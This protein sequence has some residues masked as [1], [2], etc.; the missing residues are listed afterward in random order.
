M[1][2]C[3]GLENVEFDTNLIIY[4][5]HHKTLL[6][7]LK[8]ED[9]VNIETYCSYTNIKYEDY[10]KGELISLCKEKI[11]KRIKNIFDFTPLSDSFL[12]LS[13]LLEEEDK[14]NLLKK[15][16]GSKDEKD[17]FNMLSTALN[18]ALSEKFIFCFEDDYNNRQFIIP[19][20][21]E[22]ALLNAVKKNKEFGIYE[23]FFNYATTLSSFYGVLDAKLLMEIYNRDFPENKI[24]SE[25]AVLNL[26][27]KAELFSSCNIE[28]FF[29][30]DDTV[31]YY[32]LDPADAKDI[33]KKRISYSPYIPSRQEI[34]KYYGY[35]VY[36]VQT[37]EFSELR[38]YVNKKSGS[39][40]TTFFPIEIIKEIKLGK[41]IDFPKEI[42]LFS[43]EITSAKD[44]AQLISLYAKLVSVC[45]IWVKYGNLSNTQPD[46]TEEINQND[47][48]LPRINVDLP[49][50]CVIPTEETAQKR[51]DEYLDYIQVIEEECENAPKWVDTFLSTR[52]RIKK[53]TQ[54]VAS[55]QGIDDD[56]FLDSTVFQ[57]LVTMKS[58]LKN[59]ADSS[60]NSN[61][62]FDVFD[63]GQKLDENLF[64]CKKL[65]GSPFVLFSKAIEKLYDKNITCA[66][67]VL[68][69]LGGFFVPYRIVIP[70]SSVRAKDVE[71]LMKFSAPQIYASKGFTGV[72]QF[73][74]IPV[75]ALS[76]SL[77]KTPS[78]H[79]GKLLMKCVADTRFV[80][81][82]VFEEFLTD[83]K[84]EE[85]KKI[86]CYRLQS[87]TKDE[88]DDVFI[89]I[90]KSS[91][92]TILFAHKEDLF[93]ETKAKLLPYFDS[94]HY[95]EECMPLSILEDPNTKVKFKS[96][97]FCDKLRRMMRHIGN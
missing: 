7:C 83:W 28:G 58:S 74:P 17:I 80:D 27:K 38:D 19:D 1:I 45:H 29:I 89:Y 55:I 30:H 44:Y 10:S 43:I 85:N 6:A 2:V 79:K 31:V 57:L 47:L 48:F 22:Q 87:K 36:D 84:H 4:G 76:T 64:A 95:E 77:N 50:T 69:D 37:P 92:R 41:N 3:N 70:I 73:N 68:T 39:R 21:V 97:D 63:I 16:Y 46:N 24:E 32:N 33:I 59:K 56:D 34:E 5:N 72:M 71:N 61:W 52:S 51:F 42:E 60:F 54:K 94:K 91:S 26:A 81:S 67:T 49:D 15:V 12:I 23:D 13:F 8:S 65:D 20:E 40:F 86:D 88:K 62:D 82:K 9:K 90:E 14:D 25:N 78:I 35:N 93:E 66:V 53:E 75:W 96:I 11:F 18:W